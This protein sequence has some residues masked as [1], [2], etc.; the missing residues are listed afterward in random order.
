MGWEARSEPVSGSFPAHT[1]K[2][3][4]DP[5]LVTIIAILIAAGYLKSPLPEHFAQLMVNITLVTLVVDAPCELIYQSQPPVN[6]PK[7]Q[8]S[9]IS[10]N[11]FAR[12]A[13]LYFF[14]LYRGK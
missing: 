6:F 8:G 1:L 7:Q 10:G 5:Q 4:S 13:G 3:A 11:V 14:I 2:T 12:I 9:S